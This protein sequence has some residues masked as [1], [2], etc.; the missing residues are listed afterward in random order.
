MIEIAIP[1]GDRLRLAHALLD[2]NGTLAHDGMLIGGV[3]ERV[4]SLATKLEIHVVTADTAGTAASALA[5]LPVSLAIMP[6]RFQ[7][8]AKKNELER[9]GR[10]Q[11]VAIGNGRNDFDVIAHGALS[12]VVVGPTSRCL[13]RRPELAGIVARHLSAFEKAMKDEDQD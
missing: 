12:I 1:G 5:E 11:T 2:F 10:G 6:P 9:L 8:A 3:A 13:E 7:A 4:R